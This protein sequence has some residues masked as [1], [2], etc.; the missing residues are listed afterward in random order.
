MSAPPG[1]DPNVSLLKGAGDSAMPPMIA[2]RG[3]GGQSVPP[4]PSIS[5]YSGGGLPNNYV[6]GGYK[7]S[8]LPGGNGP[9]HAMRGGVVSPSK[10][11]SSSTSGSSSNSSS[12]ST[13]GSSSN[14]SS[15][16]PSSTTVSS[17]T[18]PSSGATV[19]SSNAPSGASGSSS[20]ASPSST[21]VPSP[22]VPSSA[23][24]S[25][26]TASPSG[27]SD[28]SSTVPSGAEV[29]SSTAPSNAATD[30]AANTLPEVGVKPPN[31][32]FIITLDE[33]LEVGGNEEKYDNFI[34]KYA[35][36]LKLG[37]TTTEGADC[38]TDGNDYMELLRKI[39]VNRL[40]SYS[41]E[42]KFFQAS[43]GGPPKSITKSKPGPT[44][45]AA[46]STK[47]TETAAKST[48]PTETAAKSTKPTGTA[49]DSTKPKPP[50]ATTTDPTPS[51][52]PTVGEVLQRQ[53]DIKKASKNASK[54]VDNAIKAKKEANKKK[55]EALAAG[56]K[57]GINPQLPATKG[58]KPRNTLRKKHMKRATTQTKRL[59]KRSN[60]TRR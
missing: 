27:A 56:Q 26:S 15:N 50:A 17:P 9:M 25:P 20:T 37:V 53:N 57:I 41:R 1:F 36:C 18:A 13:S 48:K 42:C 52:G 46:K 59:L 51:R 40:E 29:P 33:F 4:T 8:L 2:M 55:Q 44:E 12:S 35:G 7:D 5:L 49:T 45:T 14:E 60:R 10:S 6:E 58:G 23:S 38:S 39:L 21:T 24:G 54:K 28:S 47:P 30:A 22:T 19:P 43:D 3:G 32:D 34:E 16:V 31:N 11:S